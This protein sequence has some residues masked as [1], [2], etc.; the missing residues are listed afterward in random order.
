M[1]VLIENSS[2]SFSIPSI[3][4]STEKEAEAVNAVETVFSIDMVCV[5]EADI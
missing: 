1:V 4:S 2:E 3:P 5:K